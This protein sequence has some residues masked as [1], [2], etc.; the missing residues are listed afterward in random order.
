MKSMS[1]VAIAALAI[2]LFFDSTTSAST[3]N[4]GTAQNIPGAS[5]YIAGQVI[6]KLGEN[7]PAAG[8]SRIAVLAFGD[9]NRKYTTQMGSLGI[10]LQGQTIETLKTRIEN[11]STVAT[12]F[13]VASYEFL[14][15][16]FLHSSNDPGGLS[17]KNIGLAREV[18][19]GEGFDVGIVGHFGFEGG[20]LNK[21]SLGETINCFVT[22]IFK[23]QK[24]EF[25]F[26][27]KTS[28]VLLHVTTIPKPKLPEA[29]SGPGPS[30]VGPNIASRF[31]VE[32][33]GKARGSSQFENIPLHIVTDGP[34]TN[35]LLLPV[36]ENRFKGQPY[37][38]RVTNKADNLIKVL[39]Q[40]YARQ[41]ADGTR[42]L[43]GEV[44]SDREKERL[45]LLAGFIDGVSIFKRKRRSSDGIVSYEKDIRSYAFTRKYVL[46]GPTYK[47]VS[48]P[49]YED[50]SGRL[51]NW[52][53]AHNP[54]FKSD[55][56]ELKIE[57]FLKP[58]GQKS[59]SGQFIFGDASESVG[60]EFVGTGVSQIG[61][62]S[63][64]FFAEKF[65]DDIAIFEPRVASEF[66]RSAGTREGDDIPTP[67]F[68]GSVKNIY[69][70]PVETWQI[71]Y[72]YTGNGSGSTPP[73]SIPIVQN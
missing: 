11:N 61:I 40:K 46:T 59:M 1:A 60:Q 28:E 26:E 24:Y 73:K 53:L 34:L 33:F 48:K 50:E 38:I 17:D 10:Q 71:S 2:G 9:Q 55:H 13:S 68:S 42:P 12:K 64:F 8:K 36:D 4:S 52:A 44:L 57:G 39:D 66:N 30:G 6:T 5:E 3:F 31:K 27:L 20:S 29:S 37:Y 70:V 16:T 21:E 62:V 15:E 23:N 19:L 56:S 49:G 7:L 22:A 45:F 14:S 72:H 47:L 54:R 35:T 65:T 32:F 18:L 41:N 43:N 63:L 69:K 51:A 25:S 67:T 58:E